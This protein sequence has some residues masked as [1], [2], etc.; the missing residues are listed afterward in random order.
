MCAPS[1]DLGQPN[2][3]QYGIF[4]QAAVN[5][6]GSMGYGGTMS[7]EDGLPLSEVQL[8]GLLSN[9]LLGQ[10]GGSS[11]AAGATPGMAFQHS[12]T[13]SATA[14]HAGQSTL[15]FHETSVSYKSVFSP[16]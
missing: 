10:L 1:A 2:A 12:A 3:Q 15:Q 8:S 4:S 13:P 14:S 11:P 16:D 9:D 6:G 7:A 5:A